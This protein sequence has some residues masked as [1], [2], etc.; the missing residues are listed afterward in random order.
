MIKRDKFDFDSVNF[1]Y[2]DGDIPCRASD[3]VVYTLCNLLGM[4]ESAIM[5]HENARNKCLTAK[6]LQLGCQYHKLQKT[7]SRFYRRHYELISKLNVELETLLREGL[8]ELDQLKLIAL[9]GPLLS[10][11]PDP[12]P[13][14]K[15]KNYSYQQ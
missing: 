3:G 7:F 11:T 9:S 4:I 6:L 13:C 12:P 10:L 14:N 15:R 5:L 2:L 8:S 1:P